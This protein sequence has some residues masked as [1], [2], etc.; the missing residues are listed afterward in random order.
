MQFQS[1]I[2]V[3]RLENKDLWQIDNNPWKVDKLNLIF[4]LK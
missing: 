4:V 3:H 2:A 1:P